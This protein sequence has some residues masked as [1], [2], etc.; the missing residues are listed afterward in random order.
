MKGTPV[1]QIKAGRRAKSRAMEVTGHMYTLHKPTELAEDRAGKI[2]DIKE[3][4]RERRR[5]K[6]SRKINFL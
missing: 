1:K 2:Y 3:K 6:S 4:S 5:H